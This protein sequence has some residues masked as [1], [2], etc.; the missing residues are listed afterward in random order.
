MSTV[1]RYP[2]ATDLR[3]SSIR[4]LRRDGLMP[5]WPLRLMQAIPVVVGV[6]LMLRGFNGIAYAEV[7]H[8]PTLRDINE[9]VTAF[10]QGNS[11]KRL[12]VIFALIF[13]SGFFVMFSAVLYVVGARKAF[14]TIEGWLL[15]RDDAN[16]TADQTV[17]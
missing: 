7:D 14:D 4:V 11:S 16:T 17:K 13:L 1:A 2:R 9:L 10:L 6:I 15:D 3:L 5:G 12:V 8:M